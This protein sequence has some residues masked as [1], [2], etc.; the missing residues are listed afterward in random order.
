MCNF[1]TSANAVQSSGMNLNSRDELIE[2]A[3]ERVFGKACPYQVGFVFNNRLREWNASILKEGKTVTVKCNK[4][5]EKVDE[6]ILIG[7]VQ[8]LL[9]RLLR[10]NV[11]TENIELYHLFLTK[12]G[13][14]APRNKTQPH[15]EASFNRLNTAYFNEL[16]EMPNFDLRKGMQ[17]LGTYDYTTDTITLSAFLLDHE[18][19]LDYI[20]Y[21]ELLHKK[22]GFSSSGVRCTHHTAK[23]RKDEKQYPDRDLLERKL[24]QVLRRNPRQHRPQVFKRGL[25][26]IFGRR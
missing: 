15:L 1:V 4:R 3:Y 6:E 13:K 7:L 11:K 17:L 19:L 5:W 18:D 24:H 26:D 10:K 8:V 21:H 12:L 16:M 22:H 23:F 20:M 9:C 25:F 2:Q 14:Y